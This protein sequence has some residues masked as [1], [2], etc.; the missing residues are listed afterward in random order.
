LAKVEEQVR[1]LE[2]ESQLS[3][4]EPKLG[5][6]QFKAFLLSPPALAFENQMK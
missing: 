1:A 3:I 4:L 2:V 6:S 5:L